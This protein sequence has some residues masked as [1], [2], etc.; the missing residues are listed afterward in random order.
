MPERT[1]SEVA[2]LLEEI[3]RRSAFEGGNPYKA[4]AYVRAAASLRSLVRS[5]PDLIR[6]GKLQTIPGVGAA[7]AKR[8]EGLYRAGTALQG[9]APR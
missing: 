6:E 9:Q 3:G 7:I 4:K 8:I 2:D 5:L 1:A